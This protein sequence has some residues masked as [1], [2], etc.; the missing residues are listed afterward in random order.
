MGMVRPLRLAISILTVS[1]VA[2]I[3]ECR[4]RIMDNMHTRPNALYAGMYMEPMDLTCTRGGVPNVREVHLGSDT[5]SKRPDTILPFAWGSQQAGGEGPGYFAAIF[6]HFAF[7]GYERGQGI[8]VL[9]S[10]PAP[11]LTVSP[12]KI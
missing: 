1:N 12:E 11:H 9:Q 2:V 3:A 5:G 7:W 4:G 8:A 6:K 10:R